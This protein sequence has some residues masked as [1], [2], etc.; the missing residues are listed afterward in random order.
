MGRLDGKITLVT[1]AARGTG[2]AIARLFAAEGA[3][4]VLADVLEELGRQVAG[5]IGGAAR[6]AKLDVTS[7]EEWKRAADRPLAEKH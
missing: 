3:Q 7:P 2:A 5:E 6:F 4:V 1:G